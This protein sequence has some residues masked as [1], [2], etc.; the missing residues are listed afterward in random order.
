MDV[1]IPNDPRRE[2]EFLD[3]FHDASESEI[4]A[5]E[6]GVDALIDKIPIAGAEFTQS[7]YHALTV[8][9]D[10]ANNSRDTVVMRT[11]V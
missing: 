2:A 1:L 7:V 10:P 4:L 9:E 8:L 3:D 5:F 6:S 11:P